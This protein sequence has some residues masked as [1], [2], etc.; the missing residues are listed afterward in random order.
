V[1][2]SGLYSGGC[3][4]GREWLEFRG[5]APGGAATPPAD[6]A[7]A[8]IWQQA[9]VHALGGVWSGGEEIHSGAEA[10]AVYPYDTDMHAGDNEVGSFVVPPAVSLVIALRDAAIAPGEALHDGVLDLSQLPLSRPPSAGAGPGDDGY[11][12]ALTPAEGAELRLVGA[13]PSGACPI[14]LLV[15]GPATLGEPGGASAFDGALLVL[16]RLSVCGPSVLSGHLFAGDLLVSAPLTVELASDWRT[17]PLAG[18]ASPV[19]E[20]RDGP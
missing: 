4:R 7:H 16:G 8:A 9:G 2:G 5:L 1:A 17:R 14:V 20:S 6:E 18:L 15:Q 12:V 3:L 11:V 19:L 13:R 10:S